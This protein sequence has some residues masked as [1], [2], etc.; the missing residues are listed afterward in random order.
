ML[1]AEPTKRGTGILLYGHRDDLESLYE[2][3]HHLA[4][5]I[6]DYDPE[7]KGQH[8]ILMCLAYDLRKAYM[9]MRETKEILEDGP[10]NTSKEIF[11]GVAIVWTDILI[12]ANALRQAASRI[13]TSKR[14]QANIYSLEY[15][16]EQA[17]FEYDAKGAQIIKGLVGGGILT[18][19]ERSFISLQKV[20]M[21]FILSKPGLTRFRKI[22]DLIKQ[23]YSPYSP[24]RKVFMK[25][26]ESLAKKHD[27]SVHDLRL[28]DYPEPEW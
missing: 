19:D 24:D 4:G 25:H 26:L 11:Y 6:Y 3:T 13:P 28:P 8:E 1:I 16:V 9:G 10:F 23:Y 2:T 7:P 20:Q 22:P 15:T 17:L 12:Y 14:D 21:E 18:D 27:C 5:L